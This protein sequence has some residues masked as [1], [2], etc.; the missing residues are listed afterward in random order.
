MFSI[1]L[2][3]TQVSSF[4]FNLRQDD[5]PSCFSLY[6]IQNEDLYLTYIVSGSKDYNTRVVL[7]TPSNSIIY[8]S[9]PRTREATRSFK[10]SSEG[11]Y[12]L[13]FYNK[14]TT[15]KKITFDLAKKKNL[16]SHVENIDHAHSLCKS[17]EELGD[18]L[19]QVAENVKVKQIREDVHAE[20]SDRICG[21][22]VFGASCKMAG[23]FLV[24]CAQVY[25]V[26]KNFEN[27]KISV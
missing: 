3:I 24:F 18:K 17:F 4:S 14:D 23:I 15:S 13:C 6:A 9:P 27:A 12:K 11:Y 5:K 8:T 21:M 26:L 2:L 10:S 22:V 16:L 19:E 7:Y 20:L 25:F 1:L